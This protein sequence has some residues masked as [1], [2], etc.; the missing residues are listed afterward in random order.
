LSPVLAKVIITSSLLSKNVTEPFTLEQGTLKYP[1]ASVTAP[2][3][4][5]IEKSSGSKRSEILK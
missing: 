3:I 4:V 1:D 2:S 5:K